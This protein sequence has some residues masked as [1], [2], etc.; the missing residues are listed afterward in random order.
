V[1]ENRPPAKL[2]I[3]L[4]ASMWAVS[5]FAHASASF[6]RAFYDNDADMCLMI[7]GMSLLSSIAPRCVEFPSFLPWQLPRVLEMRPRPRSVPYRTGIRLEKS[8]KLLIKHQ[9]SAYNLTARQS[10]KQFSV[11]HPQ[12]WSQKLSAAPALHWHCCCCF[13]GELCH[14][15]CYALV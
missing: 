13:P 7:D 3:G 1:K 11:P 2:H 8:H 9:I 6:T 10:T 5:T 14:S 12:A 4:H 15:L